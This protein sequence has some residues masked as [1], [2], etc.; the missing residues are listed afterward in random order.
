MPAI[1]GIDAAWG[2]KAPSGVALIAGSPRRGGRG[3]WRCVALAPSAAAFLALAEGRAVDWRGGAFAG[4][5]VEAGRMAAAARALGAGELACVCV[6]MPLARSPIL[7]RRVCDNAIARAYV[8]VHSPSPERP[9]AFGRA[10]QAGF[11]ALGFVLATADEA[12]ARLPR[13]L[14][15]VYPHAALMAWLGLPQRLP[16]KVSRSARYWPDLPP[17]ARARRLIGRWRAIRDAL[18]GELGPVGLSLP[19]AGRGL[20]LSALKRHEDALDALICAWV[21]TRYWEGRAQAYGD[22]D[23]AIWTPLAEVDRILPGTVRKRRP[24]RR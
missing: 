11:E 14:L 20:Q 18:A 5:A 24:G 9:G 15:E 12:N 22:G 1:L 16:Y 7:G 13:A 3:G 19:R 21:G 17:E 2:S 6:D 23:A 10:L 4:G 8:G